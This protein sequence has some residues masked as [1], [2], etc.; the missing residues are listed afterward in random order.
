VKQGSF[1]VPAKGKADAILDKS[2]NDLGLNIVSVAKQPAGIEKL[3]SGRI[4]LWDQYGGSMS[5]GWLRWILEQN[6]FPF[7]VIYAKEIDGGKLR[8]KY[9]VII[10]VSGAIPSLTQGGQYTSRDNAANEEEIPAEYRQQLGRISA[11]KS[12]PELKKFLEAGGSVITIGSSTNLAFHLNLPVRIA[13][14]EIINGKAQPLP[15]AKYFIPGSILRVSVNTTNPASWGM[16]AEADLFFDNSPVFKLSS[17]AVSKG[18]LTPLAWFATDKV[19]RSG[20]AWGQEYLQ[21]GVAAFTAQVGSGTF[22]AFGPEIPFRGQTL[23][24]YK[25]LFNQLY[26]Y[27]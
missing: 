3:S 8:E 9:D 15:M 6:K 16:P 25:F 21:D 11:D 14:T 18:E 19:L 10:F 2:A 4:A 22:S 7:N 5:S 24:T 27:K 12:I 17:D 13:T 20:W 1:F 26:N 23:G